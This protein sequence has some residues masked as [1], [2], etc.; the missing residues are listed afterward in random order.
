MDRILCPYCPDGVPMRMAM[1]GTHM[2]CPNCQS[3]SPVINNL[4][5]AVTEREEIVRVAA[6]RRYVQPM[7]PEQKGRGKLER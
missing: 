4:H 6:R 3:G 2:R 1:G 7:L 5:T